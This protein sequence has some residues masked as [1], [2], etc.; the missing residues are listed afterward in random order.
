[1][2]SNGN[3]PSYHWLLGVVGAVPWILITLALITVIGFS[4]SIGLRLLQRRRLL[5]GS[6][7][8]LEVT[9]P[10]L[11]DKSQLAT[12]QLV[13]LLHQLSSPHSLV[14][15][16][17][18]R[19]AI[20]SLEVV[21]SRARGIRY[22]LYLAKSDAA[23]VQREI[24]A[25][26]PDARFKKV[27]DYTA[28]LPKKSTI[29]AVEFRQTG[30]P[31]LPLQTQDKLSQHDPVSYM[32]GAMTQLKTGE[33]IVFQLLLS[34]LSS[35]SAGS[36][37]ANRAPLPHKRRS[38]AAKT[39]HVVTQTLLLSLKLIMRIIGVVRMMVL[40]APSR[41]H[42]YTIAAQTSL[43]P[44]DKVLLEARQAKLSQ[45][46]YRADVRALIVAENPQSATQRVRALE[47]SLASFDVSNH[48]SLRM[49]RRW[50]H[51]AACR[52]NLL[53]RLPGVLPGGTSILSATEVA[54]LYH[55]PY[56]A[57]GQT[58]NL[59]KSL[60]R[61][62]PAPVSLKGRAKYDVL[63]GNNVHL[64]MKTPIGLTAAERERHIYITGG[65]GNGKTTM[66][67]YA[68]GQDIRAGK[69]LAIIDPHGD[70]AET[71]LK[72]IPK[73]RLGDVIYFNPDDVTYPVGLNLLEIPPGLTG[74][75][76][77]RE[78]DLI[79]ETVISVFRKI[80]SGDDDGGH[81][82]EYVL[83]NTI[84]TALTVEGATIFTIFRLLTNGKFR[85]QTV[86]DLEDQDLKDFWNNEMG[87]AGEFQRIKMSAGITAKVG[88]FLF[89][90]SAKR[91]LGQPRSTIDFDDIIN[92]GKILICNFS[93]GLLGEDTASLFGI[94][95][96]AKLQI[97][98]LRRA[99]MQPTERKPFYL[100]VDEFQNFATMSF[101]QLM[102]EAR[103]YKLF[104]NMAEQ[105][106]SQQQDER[107]TNIILANV[108]TVICFRSAS[109]ADERFLL[110]VFAPFIGSGE[111][112]YLPPFHFYI[113][114][115]AAKSQEPFS[116]ETV[117][118]SDPGT[119]LRVQQVI[120]S[121]REKY[122]IQETSDA[123]VLQSFIDLDDYEIDSPLALS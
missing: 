36:L 27:K 33:L 5:H 115:A 87:K 106:T 103:K 73:K 49:K 117:L 60:S 52:A 35:W 53:S 23:L 2:V 30:H 8:L 98:T 92:S 96:L 51:S 71:I 26:L 3:N 99:R 61:S 122:T 62:L 119:H 65:T 75:E 63:L 9:P 100:Y 85:R 110:P 38:R 78:K 4:I 25:Y 91:I 7:V 20:L 57:G 42:R 18:Q 19:N 101:V 79:T 12:S 55:F 111:I 76:L 74:D 58:E 1:M 68:M 40:D 97:A 66:L 80:F 72:Y 93:K 46:L 69:G 10:A 86:A 31:S 109:P 48:Q 112:A 24:A 16:L 54:D 11:T 82:I 107:I 94:T 123:P 59:V 56:G 118:L 44:P 89:S 43:S 81:R 70:L 88:R 50:P 77:V 22:M 14:D 47:S 41:E 120:E 108:G 90:G 37:L 95:V 6:F 17:L 105:S 21:S 34:P 29:R 113:R 116:G 83:R 121:S 32:T 39:L 15:K 104:L 45:P 67:L 64:G 13:A 84:Q 102:S 114:I 28:T